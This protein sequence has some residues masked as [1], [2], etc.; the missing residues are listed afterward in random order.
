MLA[1]LM[2][3][4]VERRSKAGFKFATIDQ[5]RQGVMRCL[6]GQLCEELLF[7]SLEAQSLLQHFARMPDDQR[8]QRHCR[9]QICHRQHELEKPRA[10]SKIFREGA[11]MGRE[12]PID[13][14]DLLLVEGC[15]PADRGTTGQL[16]MQ[17]VAKGHQ[18]I[19]KWIRPSPVP[20]RDFD[21][22]AVLEIAEEPD[23]SWNIGGMIS[24]S[25]QAVPG[26][27]Q[28]GGRLLQRTSCDPVAERNGD[29]LL[30]PVERTLRQRSGNRPRES[31]WRLFGSSTTC[32]RH[33]QRREP[34]RAAPD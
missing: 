16:L 28:I 18:L 14:I 25:Q 4:P 5:A 17:A 12:P 19:Q 10:F 15:T 27:I 30:E 11:C 22:W 2:G 3:Q 34:T 29:R 32:P 9:Q 24:A 20:D 6:P 31:G 26:G 1:G 33:R 8:N 21:I 13:E 23:H 7:G